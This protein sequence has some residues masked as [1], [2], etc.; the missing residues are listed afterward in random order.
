M[1][2]FFYR[3]KSATVIVC[4]L[5]ALVF[6]V[7]VTFMRQGS[8]DDAPAIRA[9]QSTT[10]SNPKPAIAMAAQPQWDVATI[11]QHESTLASFMQCMAKKQSGSTIVIDP[12]LSA[13]ARTFL[14][15]LQEDSSLSLSHVVQTS[16]Y[17]T[18]DLSTMPTSTTTCEWPDLATA[19]GSLA[20]VQSVGIAISPPVGYAPASALI[21]GGGK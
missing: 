14:A 10:P 15:Q 8:G 5:V 1:Q 16:W 20:H 7:V 11:S 6:G 9:V 17:A 13:Q 2:Y 18:V 12:A 21:I 3:Y 19:T 4:L